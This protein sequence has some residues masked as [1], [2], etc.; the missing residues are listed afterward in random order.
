VGAFYHVN[1]IRRLAVGV[2]VG[3]VETL[4]VD[5]VD[6]EDARVPSVGFRAIINLRLAR[7]RSPHPDS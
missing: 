6:E 3:V 7:S 5:E 1:R 4:G 2:A